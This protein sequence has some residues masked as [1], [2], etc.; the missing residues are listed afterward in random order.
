MAAYAALVSLSQTIDKLLQDQN[1]FVIFPHKKEQLISIHKCTISLQGFLENFPEKGNS[2][3]RR[4]RYVANEAENIIEYFMWKQIDQG[5][6]SIS[7]STLEPGS[8]GV[9]HLIENA[10]ENIIKPFMRRHIDRR[11]NSPSYS[12]S[13]F[14]GSEVSHPI[15]MC[16][17]FKN[18][19]D[20]TEEIESIGREVMDIKNSDRSTDDDPCVATGSSLSS[21]SRLIIGPPT[22]IDPII[23]F[24]DDLLEIKGRLC[25]E[26]DQLQV[27]PILG[28]GG[29]GKTTLAKNAYD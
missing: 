1:R 8:S 14:I 27:I 10:A 26:S 18:L 20:V 6:N 17:G 2:L 5:R 11:R 22:S 16:F 13:E 7:Q 12:I 28:M 15:G 19:N 21:S 29:I 23:G 24:E 25:G 4:I 9:S 3:E